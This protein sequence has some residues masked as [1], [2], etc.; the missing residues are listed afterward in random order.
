MSLETLFLGVAILALVIALSDAS[1]Q[2]EE[3]ASVL[4]DP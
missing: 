1:A 3:K 4:R 2:R